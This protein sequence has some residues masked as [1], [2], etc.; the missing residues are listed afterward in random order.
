MYTVE[1]VEHFED[2][3]VASNGTKSFASFDDA[4]Q[5]LADDCMNVINDIS[6][7]A[8]IDDYIAENHQDSAEDDPAWAREYSKGFCFSIVI[9]DNQVLYLHLDYE[10]ETRAISSDVCIEVDENELTPSEISKIQQTLV[11]IK[12]GLTRRSIGRLNAAAEL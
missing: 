6:S 5:S 3:Y 12:E 7:G 9:D 8:G 2:W 1:S 11:T 4:M 10:P